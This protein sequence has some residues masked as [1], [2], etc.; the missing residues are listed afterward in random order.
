MSQTCSP[1]TQQGYGLVRVCRVWEVARSTG[2]ATKGRAATPAVPPRRR[3]PKPRWSDE[4]LVTAIRAV[5]AA[6][7]F[8]G[9]G[10]R[11]VWARLRW[12]GVRTSKARGLRL[13]RAAQLLAPTRVGHAHG[14]KAHDGTITTE[15]P[16]QMWGMDA[17]SCLTREGTAT[18]FGVV[19]HCAAE[20]IGLH[21]AKPGTRFEAV[22]PLRQGIHALFGGD[23]AGSARGLLARHDHGSQYVSDYFQDELKFLGIVSSPAFVREPE[24]NGV[25]ERFIRTL[26]EQRLWVRTFD[27]VEELRQ[28]LLEFKERYNRAWL[29]ERH[30]HQTPAQVRAALCRR[31]A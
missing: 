31:A 6:A 4:A 17:T 16:D 29:C 1:S 23:E 2:Y 10:H 21:A 30:G 7:P 19:D 24:G 8:L 14:P 12:Q 26:K 22:E 18:V 9:E 15:Q 11:K 27:T 13:M 5:L 20:C 3:G 25:A 28:A